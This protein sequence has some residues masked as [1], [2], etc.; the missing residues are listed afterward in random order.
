MDL[1]DMAQDRIEADLES[2]R[3]A[4]AEHIAKAGKMVPLVVDGVLMCVDCGYPIEPRRVEALPQAA[5][6]GECQ[7]WF[8]L[9]RKQCSQIGP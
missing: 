2:Q 9:E 5:R 1:A 4:M 8:E 7:G 3:A 6:C